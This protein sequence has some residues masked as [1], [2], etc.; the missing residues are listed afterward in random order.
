METVFHLAIKSFWEWRK[1][2]VITH[3][4]FSAYIAFVKGVIVGGL[5]IYWYFVGF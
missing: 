5:I 2:F 1:N 3:P 4:F